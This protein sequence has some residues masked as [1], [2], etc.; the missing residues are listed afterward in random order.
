MPL[1]R[2]GFTINPAVRLRIGQGSMA[3]LLVQKLE[4][5]VMFSLED[6]THS[7]LTLHNSN[8]TMQSKLVHS[9]GRASFR[10]SS[11]TSV[12]YSIKTNT[13]ATTK[14]LRF[15]SSG[16]ILRLLHG[17]TSIRLREP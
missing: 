14:W 12:Y 5:F 8:H 13:L 9:E 1:S 6:S 2:E 15:L 4:E 7:H 16:E 17:F 3:Q 10:H 11:K